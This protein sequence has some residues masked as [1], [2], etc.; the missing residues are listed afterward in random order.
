VFPESQR[1]HFGKAPITQVIAQVIFPTVLR[2]GR[3]PAEFQDRIRGTFPLYSPGVRLIGAPDDGQQLPPQLLQMLQN[4]AGVTAHNFSTAKRDATITLTAESLSL[5]ATSYTK[6]EDFLSLFR[7][8]LG[9]LVLQY[10]PSFFTRLGLRYVNAIDKEKLGLESN[11]PWSS[12]IRREVLGVQAVSEI[13]ASLDFSANQVRLNLPNDEGTL[14]FQHGVSFLMPKRVR[15]YMLDFDFAKN[16][17]IEVANAEPTLINY[18]Q[19]AGRA[20]R[21]CISPELRERLGPQ[22]MDDANASRAAGGDGH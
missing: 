12:L 14:T 13:E 9:A 4:N 8:P 11:H 22:P 18:H 21:W 16:G 1:L 7:E 6:W 17:Q 15:V 2:I 5:T 3:S 19:L 10:A 20:F